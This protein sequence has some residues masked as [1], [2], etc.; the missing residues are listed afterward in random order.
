[1]RIKRID[2]DSFGSV[3]QW[4]S[5]ELD[6]GINVI[7]GPNEAGKSTITEFIRSTLFPIR[8]S[9]YPGSA[10]TDSGTISVTMDNGDERTLKR[11]Q[12]KISEVSGKRT[13]SEE[14]T[15]LDADTYRALYGLDLE[16][17]VNSKLISSGD[18]RSR[19]MTIPGGDN[20]PKIT[21]DINDRITALM[22]KDRLTDNK[23]IGACNKEIKDI[24]R[25]IA[26]IR[27]EKNQYDALFEEREELRRKVNENR[28]LVEA[29]QNEKLKKKMMRAQSSNLKKLEELEERRKGLEPYANV[30]PDDRK[31]YDSLKESITELKAELPEHMVEDK[32][33]DM[34]LSRREDIEG[35]HKDLGEY[36]SDKERLSGIKDRIWDLST[37]IDRLQ[38]D[39][40]WNVDKA[41]SV[42][43]GS[44]IVMKAKSAIRRD[45]NKAGLD[46]R[47]VMGIAGAGVVFVLIG[48]LFLSKIIDIGDGSIV[49]GLAIGGI[50]LLGVAAAFMIPRLNLTKAKESFDWNDWIMSEGYPNST[51]PEEA[52]TLATDLQTMKDKHKEMVDLQQQQQAI[53]AE[54]S[55]YERRCTPIANSLKVDG[56]ID[57]MVDG[58]YQK[59]QQ[60]LIDQMEAE[61]I[62][63]LMDSIELKNKERNALIRKYGSEDELYDA[64]EG[65]VAYDETQKE[66]ATISATIESSSGVSLNELRSFLTDDEGVDVDVL[67]DDTEELSQRIGQLSTQ[68]DNIMKDD[69]LM[70]LEN[71]RSGAEARMRDALRE[72]A[73]YNIANAMIHDACDHFYSD[74][75]PSVVKAA[76]QYLSTMTYG[77]YRLDNDPANN[78]IAVKDNRSSK[79]S[80]KWS[81]GLGDQVYLSLKMALAQEMGSEK[82]PMIMDD[83]LVRFDHERKEAACK[84]IYEFSRENQ[85]IMFT[86]D[87]SLANYFRI[88]GTVNEIRL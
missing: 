36:H 37:D 61:R 32:D 57:T 9:K 13:V 3:S 79:T 33:R 27:S 48:I 47:T 29:S 14:F 22:N 86:C 30:N 5:G 49:V 76:N 6:D 24:D 42:R 67:N 58:V 7:Y 16:Q 35:L 83:I 63:G 26:E 68:M 54:I 17:L 72:W 2:I 78:E 82:M 34:V 65:K 23:V 39:T 84:A 40:G 4:H 15:S 75:Q 69:E 60:A 20:I 52:I 51:T 66:I 50:G 28:T 38:K 31:R 55:L 53:E 44:P 56:D 43:T 74:L 12:K 18:F 80:D 19:F 77:R 41:L 62:K 46:D 87:P 71:R 73:V 88:H 21:E 45:S 8:I 81:S 11:E 10:K 70:D 1:M 25:Q 85:V 64:C 59:L